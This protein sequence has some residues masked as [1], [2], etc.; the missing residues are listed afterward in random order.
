MSDVHVKTFYLKKMDFVLLLCWRVSSSTVV[1]PACLILCLVILTETKGCDS[2]HNQEKIVGLKQR[3]FILC[4]FMFYLYL[5]RYLEI[6]L[7][8]IP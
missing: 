8:C 3:S 2:M 5:Y 4:L 1:T 7:P 6:L